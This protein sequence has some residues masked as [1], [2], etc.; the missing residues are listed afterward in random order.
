MFR[1]KRVDETAK[2]FY[3]GVGVAAAV[4]KQPEVEDEAVADVFGRSCRRPLLLRD[5]SGPSPLLDTRRA[6]S[7]RKR[8]GK[9]LIS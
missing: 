3:M 6:R 8:G 4:V 7:F 1:R 2:V 5:G 9:F